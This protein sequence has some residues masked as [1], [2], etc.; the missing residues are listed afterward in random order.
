[1]AGLNRAAESRIRTSA[2]LQSRLNQPDSF[3]L[4]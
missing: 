4:S 1:M 2:D 3:P